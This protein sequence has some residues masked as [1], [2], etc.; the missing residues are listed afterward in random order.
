MNAS[1]PESSF[2]VSA[3]AGSGKT[4]VLTQRLLRLLLS[5]VAAEKILCITFTRAAAAEILSRINKSL[6]DWAICDEAKLKKELAA[7]AGKPARETEIKLARRLFANVIDRPGCLKIQ[8][9]HAFCQAVLGRF[10][11]E[12]GLT[13]NFRVIDRQTAEELLDEAKQRLLLTSS[14]DDAE[15]TES[16][17]NLASQLHEERFSQIVDEIM[18]ERIHLEELLPQKNKVLENICG[19]LGIEKNTDEKSLT[20]T[21]INP[22]PEV[23]GIITELKIPS[24]MEYIDLPEKQ[25]RIEHYINFF[26]TQKH[27][28]RKRMT[29]ELLPEQARVFAAVEAMKSIQIAQDTKD[30]LNVAEAII[31]IYNHLKRVNLFLDYDDLIAKTLQLLS[32]RKLSAW[33]MYKLDGGIDHILVDEAQD[34]S[35]EQWLIIENIAAEF[36]SGNGSEKSQ[37]TVFFVGD[38]KQSI[39]S[40]QGAERRMFALMHDRFSGLAKNAG[41]KWFSVRMEKSFRSTEA[42]L[43]AVNMVF[44]RGEYRAA[45]TSSTSPIKHELERIGQPGRVEIW[46]LIKALEK[47]QEARENYDPKNILASAIAEKITGWIAEGRILHGKGRKIRPGD[48]MI[49]VRKRDEFIDYLTRALKNK[50]IPASG[51]DRMELNR[52]IAVMDL[53]AVAEFLLLPEDDLNLATVLK[54]PFIGFSEDDL[55]VL[56]FGRGVTSLW[57][58][59]EEKKGERKIFSQ[60]Y[61]YLG[62][63]IKSCA[64]LRPFELFSELLEKNGGREKM[65]ARLGRQM[66]DP[67]NEL[68]NLTLQYEESHSVSLQGFLHWLAKGKIEIKRDFA[69][70]RDEV[71]IMTVHAAKGMESPIVFLVDSTAPPDGNNRLFWIVGKEMEVPLYIMKFANH[72]SYTQN[73]V[74]AG[75]SAVYEEYL[76]LLY[77]AMTRAE[78]ELY[79]TGAG[80]TSKRNWYGVITGEFLQHL[81]KIR[82]QEFGYPDF[83]TNYEKKCLLLENNPSEESISE[84]E[85]YI[86][87]DNNELLPKI[88]RVTS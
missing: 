57:Q 75:K 71:K 33:V 43:S 45:I 77:V 81:G 67:L 47:G 62:W 80:N 76:R 64:G 2:W 21:L 49:L 41:K 50:G 27:E 9:I 36:F 82:E 20:A 86:V 5:G 32:N 23:C 8:T 22:Q 55:F 73:L 39:F 65:I 61:E 3:S 69:M 35:L 74:L 38:E 56:A 25:R 6:A 66:E 30:F 10:P 88:F 44:A 52:Q 54:S 68:L 59:L 48:I 11:L 72:N 15:L 1:D 12:A 42:V 34:T 79:I 14:K 31:A 16:L 70:V 84:E 13:P 18:H 37:K 7:L 40:F 26:L 85:G 58:T 83:V 60:A 19:F 87:K 24:L 53:L 51:V 46:P 4:T 63:I 29:K 78:D 17:K 28:P